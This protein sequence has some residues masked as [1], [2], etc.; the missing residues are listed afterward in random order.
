[1]KVTPHFDSA[2][3]D[4]RAWSNGPAV[5]YP[6][7]WIEDRLKPLCLALELLRAEL[8]GRS[9]HILSGYRSPAFNKSIEGAPLSQHVQGRAADIVVAEVPA[10]RVHAVAWQLIHDGLAPQL[11]GIGRYATFTHLDVRPTVR[12]K[13]WPK[14]SKVAD[15][16]P[17]EA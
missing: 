1:M 8:G 2:E 4:Q 9:I 14:G 11:H 13:Y 3:F 17:V 15:W 5:A 10:A 6:R 16:T 12:V 7:K